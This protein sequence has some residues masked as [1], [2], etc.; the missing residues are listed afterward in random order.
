M[1]KVKQPFRRV[2]SVGE[3]NSPPFKRNFGPAGMAKLE[4]CIKAA[5]SQMSLSAFKDGLIT[6]VAQNLPIELCDVL[7]RDKMP[8]VPEIIIDRERL[9]R[10]GEDPFAKLLVE[11]E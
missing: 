3:K 9:A 4:L 6:Y 10:Y 8:V 2:K 5:S 7:E 1:F 11:T